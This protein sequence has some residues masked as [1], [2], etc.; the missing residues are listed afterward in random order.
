[1]FDMKGVGG[2]IIVTQRV[3]MVGTLMAIDN[4]WGHCEVVPEKQTREL[5]TTLLPIEPLWAAIIRRLV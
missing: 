5:R 1:M 4:V 3:S 2:R